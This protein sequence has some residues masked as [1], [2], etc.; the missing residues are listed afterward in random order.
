MVLINEQNV[1]GPMIYWYK[2]VQAIQADLG[3]VENELIG[4]LAV[5]GLNFVDLSILQKELTVNAGLKVVDLTDSAA[6]TLGKKA[7]AD[8]VLYGK[9]VAV[10]SSSTAVARMFSSQASLSVRLVRVKDGTIMSAGAVI[11]S[12]LHGEF[13]SSGTKALSEAAR[14]ISEK[15]LK[16]LEAHSL[17][18]SDSADNNDADDGNLVKTPVNTN[19]KTDGAN[20]SV[21]I[22]G[23]IEFKDLQTIIKVIKGISGVK[24][25]KT[26]NFSDTGHNFHRF[27]DSC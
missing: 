12:G 8:F 3:V 7:G 24:N 6:R 22:V 2:K 10:K 26:V 20:I 14:Q 25:V 23:T 19:S 21:K 4:N 9:A 27:H 17:V 11:G 5:K 15:L 1:S 16:V 13:I 18:S